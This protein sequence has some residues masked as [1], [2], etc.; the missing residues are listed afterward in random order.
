MQEQYVTIETLKSFG[1]EVNEA[2][3]NSLLEHVNNTIDERVGAEITESLTDEQLKQLL[4][5]QDNGTEDQIGE[6]IAQQVPDYAQI[7]QDNIDI[8][9]GEVAENTDNINKT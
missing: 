9:L 5:I 7:I 3:V 1:I 4:E 8:T 6:W 2:T